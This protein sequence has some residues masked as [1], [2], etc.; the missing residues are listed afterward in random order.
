MTDGYGGWWN[1][2]IPEVSNSLNVLDATR[3]K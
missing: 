3:E 2:G 1:V